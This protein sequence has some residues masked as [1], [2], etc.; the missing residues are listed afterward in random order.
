L[1]SR[2]TAFVDD[3]EIVASTV[4][5]RLK[6]VVVDV[7]A[8]AAAETYIQIWDNA[9]P[10]PGTT[11]PNMVLPVP[12]VAVMGARRRLKFLFAAGHVFGTALSW[13]PTTTVSG[14]T[15]PTGADVPLAVEL[16]FEKL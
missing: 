10:D 9:T 8:A 4:A 1:V 5:C 3:T 7:P 12:R 11:A 6:A 15:V 16:H 13:L 14:Q 2:A